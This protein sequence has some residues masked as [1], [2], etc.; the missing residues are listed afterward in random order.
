MRNGAEARFD[1]P[2]AAARGD[3]RPRGAA[4]RQVRLRRLASD[5]AGWGEELPAGEG[6]GLAV[7]RSF[8]SCVAAAARVKIVD[9]GI[10][11]PQTDVAIDCGFPVNPERIRSQVEG[12]ASW[13]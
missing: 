12:P 11:V 10:T 1:A 3:P 2:L 7:H 8:L 4:R 9:G 6:I 5:A 13:T